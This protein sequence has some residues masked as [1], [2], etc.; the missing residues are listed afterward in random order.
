VNNVIKILLTNNTKTYWG[1]ELHKGLLPFSVKK[2]RKY[3]EV[4]EDKGVKE[5]LAPLSV[6][7][8]V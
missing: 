3:K 4:F 5:Y 1:K 7:G 8:L 2:A 6:Q